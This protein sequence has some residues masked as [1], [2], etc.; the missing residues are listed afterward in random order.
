[1]PSNVRVLQGASTRD[2][3]IFYVDEVF[4]FT[5]R[6]ILLLN[7]GDNFSGLLV[8]FLVPY[9]FGFSCNC[10]ER[11]YCVLRPLIF[12]RFSDSFQSCNLAFLKF[13]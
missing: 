12:L 5:S 11:F 13:R 4:F 7:C 3:N 1:M 8:G 6:T 10:R 2:F 9:L